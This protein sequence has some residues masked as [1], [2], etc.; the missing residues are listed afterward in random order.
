M[1]CPAISATRRRWRGSRR[2]SARLAAEFAE[3]RRQQK[4]VATEFDEHLTDISAQLRDV[5]ESGRDAGPLRH[6]GAD[7]RLSA[8]ILPRI[9][10]SSARRCRGLSGGSAALADAIEE[11][12]D[13]AS[14]ELLD[15]LTTEDG[16][17]L[18][19]R[20]TRR[21]RPARAATS[22]GSTA[23]STSWRSSSRR[24]RSTFRAARS[25]RSRRV[26]TTMQAHPRRDRQA[27]PGFDRAV[28]PLGAE[29]A[30]DFRP[31]RH[32]RRRRRARRRS[33]SAWRRSR[34][35]IAGLASK[36]AGPARIADAA[37][38]DRQPP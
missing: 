25:S 24:R 38:C 11:Q 6:R 34:A 26:S 9:A 31:R 10:A 13:D 27:R 33:R 8:R 36:S 28:P 1:R 37:R 30:G 7:F 16:R 4:S 23:S 18:P 2:S 32:A 12:E 14:A 15:G 20:S 35:A 17:A 29:A 22:A 21:T 19:P 3:A 5:A